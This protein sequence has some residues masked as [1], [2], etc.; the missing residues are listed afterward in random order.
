[1]GGGVSESVRARWVWARVGVGGEQV[2]WAWAG[3]VGGEWVSDVSDEWEGWMKF[4]DCWLNRLG[5]DG[6]WDCIV[7]WVLDRQAGE[8]GVT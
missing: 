1:M 6:E 3:G 5:G 2:G 8:S 7:G 4:S